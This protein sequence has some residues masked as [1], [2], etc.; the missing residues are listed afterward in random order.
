MALTF[1]PNNHRYRLD[2]KSVRG[3]TGLIGG[4]TPKDA[5]IPW[6]AELAGQWALD[7]LNELPY[8]PAE[9]ALREMKWAHRQARDAAAIKGTAVHGIAQTIHETGEA[10]VAEEFMPFITGYLDFLDTW[11][12][13]P[14]LTERPCA[15][16]EHW[17]AGTFDLIA[18]SP[19]I[20]GGAPVQIDLK[21]SK[22][23]RAEVAMQTAAY[24]RAEFY[25][26]ADGNEQPMPQIAGNLV[27]HV[28]P[29]DRNG[30]HAR[31]EGSPLGTSLYMV[32]PDSDT[33]GTHFDWFL[34]AAYT[35]KNTAAR[36]RVIGEPM[37]PDDVT[38]DA[39]A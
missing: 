14:I 31:Y 38:I 19:R 17:Y 2:G 12:I 34:A 20:L 28:T 39:A 1:N 16:R 26:D 11:D 4:G 8:M 15:S 13:T 33:I 18:T 29:T 7:H 37:T 30:E 27:A 25:E 24:A 21:T 36:D 32:A 22:R 35:A 9:N 3:V 6:A 10:D 23:P 5:L